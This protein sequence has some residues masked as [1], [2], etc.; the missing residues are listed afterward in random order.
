MYLTRAEAKAEMSDLAGAAQDLDALRATSMTG[1]TQE[2][3]ATKE[4]LIDAI[5]NKRFKEL[6]YEGHRF[7]DL[8][9]RNLPVQRLASDAP[10]V[11]SITV[12]A[13]NFR[14]LLP[15]PGTE[16]KA[17]PQIQQNAGYER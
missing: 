15:F 11:N 3:F 10:N 13:G 1:N 7:W 16:I 9:R 5:N 4:T 2:T 17:N 14:F 12:A 8:K 6:A